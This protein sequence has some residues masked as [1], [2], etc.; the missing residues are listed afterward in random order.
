MEYLHTELYHEISFNANQNEMESLEIHR[1]AALKA[2]RNHDIAVKFSCGL[3][4]RLN[5]F[6]M[7]D[8]ATKRCSS[9]LNKY[10]GFS[11]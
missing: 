9:H 1:Q 11:I 6:L 2:V 7:Q 8:L 3:A 5:G 10:V 4:L